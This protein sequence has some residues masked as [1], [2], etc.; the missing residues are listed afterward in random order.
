[1]QTKAARNP[2][3]ESAGHPPKRDTQRSRLITWESFQK[4]YLHREDGHTYEWVRGLVEKTQ[5]TIDSTQLYIHRN[6]VAHF[7][8]LLSEQ[9]VHGELLAEADLLFFNNLHRRPDFAWLTNEQINHLAEKGAIE[10]PT[11]IIEVISTNDAAQRIAEK[12][13]DYRNSGVQVVWHVFPIQQ[14]VH[15]YS[16]DHLDGMR[17]C[18]GE[19][20]CSAD[21]V[22]PGYAF[23]AKM[24]FDKGVQGL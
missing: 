5:N 24:V 9:R 22:L 2:S 15:V 3:V 20:I 19:K 17:V 13:E 1:M 23:P 21:P 12:M 4:R 14:Q 8:A 11:F 16:G 18:Y 7:R 10:I 6:L